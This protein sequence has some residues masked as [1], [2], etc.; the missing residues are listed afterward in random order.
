MNSN[1]SFWSLIANADPIVKIIMLILLICSI[2]SWAIIVQKHLVVKKTRLDLK[3]F[4]K[5]FWSGSDLTKLYSKYNPRN[6][7]QTGVSTI[8]TSGFRAFMKLTKNK[9]IHGEPLIDG[10]ERAMRVSFS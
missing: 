4:L 1:L 9:G 2:C 5:E 3:A 8:F 10:V 6:N 7:T